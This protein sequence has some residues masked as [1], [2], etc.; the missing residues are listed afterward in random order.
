MAKKQPGAKKPSALGLR[1]HLPIEGP[2]RDDMMQLYA[3]TFEEAWSAQ[4]EREERY[5]PNLPGRGPFFRWEGAQELKELHELYKN[6]KRQMIIEALFVCALNSLPLP[7]WCEMAF[8]KSY[9]EVRQYKAK[10]WDDVFGRPHPKKAH[11]G[12]KRQEREKS[13]LVYNR[14]RQIKKNDPSVAIDGHLFKTVGAELG[15]GGKTLTEEYYYKEKNRRT[16]LKKK[17]DT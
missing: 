17:I 10:S 9:R 15:I 14:I 3:W 16:G 1:E 11:L 12:A 7:R 5:G 13:Y 6:G 8:L 2:G 4:E